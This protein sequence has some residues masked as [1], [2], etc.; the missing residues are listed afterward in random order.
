MIDIVLILDSN[1]LDNDLNKIVKIKI[2]FSLLDGKNLLFCKYG[3]SCYC[4]NLLYFVEFLYFIV[5]VKKVMIGSG[6]DI[7]FIDFDDEKDKVF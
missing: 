3:V 2:K 5:V 6:S 1:D 7:D 4:K